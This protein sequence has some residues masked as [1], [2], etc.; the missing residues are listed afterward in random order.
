MF[1]ISIG[2]S[3]RLEAGMGIFRVLFFVKIHDP[4][5]TTESSSHDNVRPRRLSLYFLS[6]YTCTPYYTKFK[7]IVVAQGTYAASFL[8]RFEA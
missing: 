4:V 1:R 8:S 3:S 5:G 6:K 2:S 7:R